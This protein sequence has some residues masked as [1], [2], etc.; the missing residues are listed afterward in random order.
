MRALRLLLQR[1]LEDVK[2]RAR[3]TQA[4]DG[5]VTLLQLNLA[6]VK[7]CSGALLAQL[8]GQGGEEQGLWWGV[9]G[10][11]GQGERKG[12][13][14]TSRRAFEAV[15]T[16]LLRQGGEEQGLRWGVQGGEG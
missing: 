8:L 14:A 3:P 11:E 4:L 13:G 12:L 10:G 7:G 9:Q 1:P 15:L 5:L 6:E 16:Q 2:R